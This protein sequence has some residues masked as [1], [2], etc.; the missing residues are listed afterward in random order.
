M[1]KIM[2]YCQYL[3][4][5]GHLV[6]STEI[7]RSLVKDFEV[8]L[9]NGGQLVP[10]FKF[11]Q[12]S[13]VVYLPAVWEDG[14]ELKPVDSS[15]TIEEVKESRKQKILTTLEE[16]QPDCII[17][18]CFPF[19][20][21][22]LKFE[23]VPMLKQARSSEQEIT[24]I[25]SLRDLIMT[26]PMSEEART[27]RQQK[28]CKLIN[29][30]Y[31]LVFFHG[32]SN[33]LRLEDSFPSVDNLNCEVYYTGY[34]APA[35]KDNLLPHTTKDIIGLNQSEPTIV[36]SVG[37]GRHGYPLLEAVIAASPILKASLP[38]KI[39][40]F[41]GPFMTE[42]E[43]QK[44]QQ[45][46]AER[47]NVIVRRFT[48]RLTEYMEKADLSVS[49]GGYNT[50]MNI[51]KTKVRSL[52]LPSLNEHQSDEQSIRAEKLAGSGILDLLRR[53]DLEPSILAEKI[54]SSLK[55]EVPQN[56]FELNGA[57][58]T[59]LRLKELLHSKVTV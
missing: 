2:F 42:S 56:S 38:H 31:D 19:S 27:R 33:L 5:M 46:A 51:L 8:C 50:V 6:R 30:Y 3:A 41:A 34:V 37:G 13:Q 14:N 36:A 49:L 12:D 28:V 24:I 40:C 29:R 55:K 10:G 54:I 44:L 22:K 35:S 48:P 17:T 7:I 9:I 32:D 53:D 26:Q 1:K 15:L 4:G 11:P 47:D 45:A 16:F 43:F 59:S 57:K 23:L 25:C 39:H 52:L 21:H 20:K 58:A 18:E